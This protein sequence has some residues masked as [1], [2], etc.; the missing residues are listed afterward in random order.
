MFLTV[1]TSFLFAS[2][3]PSTVPEALGFSGVTK[4]GTPIL[5]STLTSDLLVDCGARKGG[6]SSTNTR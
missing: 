6:N 1:N 4:M 2:A 3:M 5:V